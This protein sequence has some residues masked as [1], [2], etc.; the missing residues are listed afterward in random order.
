M[1]L[2]YSVLFYDFIP[3][4]LPLLLFMTLFHFISF[5]KTI[6]LYAY[7]CILGGGGG[8]RTCAALPFLMWNKI[9][10]YLFILFNYDYKSLA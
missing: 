10:I 8:G 1:F 7:I 9:F 2:L 4:A 3:I 5:I 6:Y